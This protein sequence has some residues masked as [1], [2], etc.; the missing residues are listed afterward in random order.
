[1][2]PND[3]RIEVYDGCNRTSGAVTVAPGSLT[4]VD[5]PVSNGRNC[6][7]GSTV[8]YEKVLHGTVAAHIEGD[9]LTLRGPDGA[10]FGLHARAG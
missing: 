5:L 2:L 8:D 4:I 9:R 3:T 10:G 6:A 7:P 1:L